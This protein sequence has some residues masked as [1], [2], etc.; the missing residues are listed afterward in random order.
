MSH[1]RK[2]S[3][4]DLAKLSC[5]LSHDPRG[6][7]ASISPSDVIKPPSDDCL[8]IYEANLHGHLTPPFSPFSSPR[9]PL[10]YEEQSQSA[11]Y[12]DQP[13]YAPRHGSV[14]DLQ[15][16]MS[17]QYEDV[18]PSSRSSI[19]LPIHSGPPN[20]NS[21]SSSSSTD[22]SDRRTSLASGSTATTCSGPTDRLGRSNGNSPESRT[23]APIRTC[24]STFGPR[25]NSL[26]LQQPCYEQGRGSGYEQVRESVEYTRES[27]DYP[28][29][30]TRRPASRQTVDRQHVNFAKADDKLKRRRGNL[31][32]SVTEI[33]KTWFSDHIAHPYPSEEE[34][35]ELMCKTGLSMSQVGGIILV[36]SRFPLLTT[37]CR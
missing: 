20:R 27:P 25:R 30:V 22:F 37:D 3:S 19:Q 11:F 5:R 1:L 7:D 32:K 31:P 28:Q 8:R 10:R 6:P 16:N 21:C 14:A 23:L 17:P 34:K 36:V 33:L 26:L 29:P 24:E 15:R 9:R 12:E 4:C 2:D 18:Y 35:Q 13:R